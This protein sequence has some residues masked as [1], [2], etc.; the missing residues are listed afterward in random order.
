MRRI[1]PLVLLLASCAPVPRAERAGDPG[2]ALGARAGEWE[3]AAA[4]AG[5]AYALGR[6]G[7]AGDCGE[8][9]L[10]V[11]TAG[12]PAGE[13]LA[14]PLA[15][16]AAVTL[17]N[18]ACCRA[19]EGRRDAAFDAL[20]AALADGFGPVG[21]DHVR[22]DPDLLPLHG[23][24]RWE[25][26]IERL[27]WNEEVTL[28]RPPA[29]ATGARRTIVWIGGAPKPL[30]GAVVA[31]PSPPY[32]VWR[33]KRAWTTRLDPGERAARKILFAAR[34]A[35]RAGGDAGRVVL[36]AEGDE[37][38]AL[39]WEV[40]LRHPGAFTDVVL[41]GA[42]PP[43]WRLLDRG[44]VQGNTTVYAVGPR[45]FPDPRVGVRMKTEGSADAALEFIQ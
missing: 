9:A 22:E 35:G 28:L 14:E 1:A 8:R 16:E 24:P 43:S 27:S 21:F 40:L 18:I 7:E 17:Y 6:W 37:A 25:A 11:L 5:R 4:A 20:E 34:A 23:E 12:K 32:L 13:P 42:A 3:S 10:A 19:L 44:A 36:R 26:L 30:A 2:S 45:A 39:A 38:A 15:T 33:G 29:G 31:V 41:V